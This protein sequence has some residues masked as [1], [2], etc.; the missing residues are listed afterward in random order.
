MT[1]CVPAEVV[2][3]PDAVLRPVIDAGY[4]RNDLLRPPAGR[5]LP[6]RR[7][8]AAGGT[9]TRHRHTLDPPHQPSK[10]Q[11]CQSPLAASSATTRI[12]TSSGERRSTH[13]IATRPSN[14]RT[15]SKEEVAMH[16]ITKHV[17]PVEEVLANTPFPLTRNVGSLDELQAGP[18][19]GRGLLD[20]PSRPAVLV[21]PGPNPC[22]NSVWAVIARA[23]PGL[24]A[25]APSW[26]SSP[27]TRWGRRPAQR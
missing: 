25:V 23:G 4:S 13:P 14:R 16:K 21:A 17:M 24:S 19:R 7:S 8:P 26:R 2:D 12:P 1:P 20:A 5:A 22:P 10:F 9:G 6:P 11:Q 15:H 18:L 3:A 27:A